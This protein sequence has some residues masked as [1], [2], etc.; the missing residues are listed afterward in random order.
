VKKLDN[1]IIL[2]GG[3]AGTGKTTLAKE[4]SYSMNLT[5]RLG[6]GFIR[7]ILKSYLTK[8]QFPE[9]YSYTFRPEN[10]ENLKRD[11]KKQARM[12]CKAVNSSIK[13]AHEEGTSIVIEGNHLLPEYLELS[14]VSLFV[15]LDCDI[16]KIK[17]RIVG[18]T[19]SKRVILESDIENILKISKIIIESAKIH[20]IPIINNENLEASI[21]I[22][23][24][25]CNT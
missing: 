23:K 7:E 18:P 5:H 15:I 2:I 13:R 11:F 6:T 14:K 4:I 22:I 3:T 19:H 25:K 17:K 16:V 20:N 1:K 12:V 21:E 8:E 24:Q 9:L 10:S